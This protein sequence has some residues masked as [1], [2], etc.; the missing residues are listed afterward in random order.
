M[1]FLI[2][3]KA[4]D[5]FPALRQFEDNWVTTDLLSVYLKN[6]AQRRREMVKGKGK[7][8]GKGKAA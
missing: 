7:G 3:I 4:G 5:K 8:K 2:V 6:A 1:Q